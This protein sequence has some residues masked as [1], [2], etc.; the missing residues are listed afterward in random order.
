MTK[1]I[2]W[3]AAY[4][5]A[6]A[7]GLAATAV[8]PAQAQFAQVPSAPLQSAQA[9]PAPSLLSG[10]DVAA[11]VNDQVI[12][13]YEVLQRLH[14]IMVTSGIPNTPE[15]EKKLL[16]RVID[17]LVEESIKLRQADKLKITISQDD[18][19]TARK[20]IEEGNH[21][22]PGAL[23]K[24]LGQANVDSA[25]FDR[26]LRSQLAWVKAVQQT[27]RNKVS[28]EPREITAILDGLK[29]NLGKPQRHVGE[30]VLV[31]PT[32]DRDDEI[33]QLALQLVQEL[34]KGDKFDAVAR[35]FS[36]GSSA[37][38]GGDLGWVLVGELDRQE[39]LT[40][41]DLKPGEISEP[42]KTSAGWT[43]VS[44]F[45]VRT[46][47]PPIDQ[48]PVSMARLTI[49]KTFPNYRRVQLLE[50]V[51]GAA[52]CDDINSIADSFKLP[53]SGDMG[54]IIPASTPPAIRT[55]IQDLPIF[56]PSP[57]VKIEGGEV[58]LMVCDRPSSD[59]LPSRAQIQFQILD[60][61]LQQEADRWLHDL[62]RQAVVDIRF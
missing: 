44:L 11:V 32:P 27:L 37:A 2:N 13:G 7:M 52:S 22:P 9:Q 60:R 6:L 48:L 19:D 59:G 5:I 14:F 56:T 41:N 40:L 51:K 15:N 20:S 8:K 50:A 46:G 1:L 35:Q 45:D 39:E 18:V 28:A 3:P 62:R 17:Q 21:L 31:D 33:H 4:G 26:Q 43:I 54:L 30:I 12:T 58:I 34:H 36:A 23:K 38:T 29:A 24:M 53:A 42:Y 10:H 61:K 25:T 16:P 57:V 55:A 49:P 47:A